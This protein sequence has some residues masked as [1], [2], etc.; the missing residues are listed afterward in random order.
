MEDNWLRSDSSLGTGNLHK[1]VCGGWEV[2]ECQPGAAG[3]D[4]PDDGHQLGVLDHKL[5]LDPG[6]EA[7]GGGGAVHGEGGE[8]LVVGVTLEDQRL[9]AEV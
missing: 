2:T 8:C 1:K 6:L 3:G 5:K 7:G 4:V 9:L